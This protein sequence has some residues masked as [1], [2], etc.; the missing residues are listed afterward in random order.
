M[1]DMATSRR[2][3]RLGDLIK[4]E[5][6]KI[7]LQELKDPRI[8]FVTITRVK[9]SEDLRKAWIYWSVYGDEQSKEESSRGLESAKGFIRKELGR[10]VRVKYLPEIT[11]AFDDSLEYSCRI[12]GILKELK[13]REGD[14]EG[15]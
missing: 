14:E 13:G 11:F 5:V 3:E 12:E 7:V 8:G 10:R 6:S 4:E 2:A 1:S 9:L 15:T